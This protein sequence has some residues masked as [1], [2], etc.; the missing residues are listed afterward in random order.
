MSP[1]EVV[2]AGLGACQSIVARLYADKFEINLKDFS[3][4]VEGEL[5]TDGFLGKSNARPG[6]ST[7]RYT[8]NIETDASEKNVDAFIKHVEQN[9]P[10]GD[11]LANEVNLIPG[12]IIIKNPVKDRKSTRLNSSHVAISYAVFCLKKK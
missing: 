1:I 11:S 7:I 4:D 12:K 8:Y 3:V 6:F 10:V 2:L 5:D 9:C